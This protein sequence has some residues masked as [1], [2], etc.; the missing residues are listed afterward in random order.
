MLCNYIQKKDDGIVGSRVPQG[1]MMNTG[2]LSV[3]AP[4]R[5]EPPG[6][7]QVR[8]SM[9][10]AP[11]IRGFS[12]HFLLANS[13]FGWTRL[14]A[15]C[16]DGRG[17]RS[18]AGSLFPPLVIGPMTTGIHMNLQETR[19]KWNTVWEM[20]DV[21][22]PTPSFYN[23]GEQMTDALLKVHPLAGCWW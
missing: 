8:I 19:Q 2:F 9:Q 14:I 20:W 5:P 15:T 12:L 18:Q 4:P 21:T 6:T 17:D 22:P 1:D 7:H 10:A 16:T 13:Y 3:G 23:F 11:S